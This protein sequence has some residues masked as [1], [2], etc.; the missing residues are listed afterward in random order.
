MINSPFSD[1]NS[2][3]VMNYELLK[4]NLPTLFINKN[5]KM[6]YIDYISNSEIKVLL[7]FLEKIRNE[8]LER[9][10]RFVMN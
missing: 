10:N 4:N 9:M 7:C 1:G 5:D 3:T 8:D 6:K 2:R